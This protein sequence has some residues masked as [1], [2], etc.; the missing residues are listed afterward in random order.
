MCPTAPKGSPGLRICLPHIS[1]TGAATTV[2]ASAYGAAGPLPAATRAGGHFMTLETSA[3]AG[4]STSWSPTPSTA[5]PTA[6][7]AST[8]TWS[9]WPSPDVTILIACSRRRS[10][11][12]SRTVCR[13]ARRVGTS[14]AIIA[15]SSLGPR[16]RT[17]SRP[18]GKKNLARI[19]TD[20]LAR[21][22][23][24]FS[25][26]IAVD[27]LYDGP[28]CVLSLVDNHTF[29][30]LTSRVLE[31]D[32]TQDD[33][34]AFLRDFQAHLDASGLKVL[35]VTTDGSNLYPVPLAEVFPDVPHQ[36]CRF[37]VLKE[38]TKAVLHALAKL[39]KEMKSRL[40][41]R[42]RGR[43]K[44]AQAQE[45]RRAQRQEQRINDLFEH[46][47]LF[48]RKKL[49]AAEKRTFQRITRG[50]PHWRIL[51]SI[52]DE[53]YRLFDRRCRAATALGRLAKLRARV[54]RF[55]WI[56]RALEKLYTPNLEKALTFLDDKLLPGTSN[57]VERGNRRYRKAQRNVYSVRTAEHI[58][59][60]IA[61]DMYREQRSND[62]ARATKVLHQARAGP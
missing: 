55:R 59:Q 43:P 17:G 3:P 2:A 7:A 23:E 5:A 19:P 42:P 49:T 46:R 14:G 16:S 15:S 25:G 28:F 29:T 9:T 33:I 13:I 4:R 24:R 48:V 40:P 47:Y 12:S 62:R 11:W 34:L 30:R 1:N 57:A 61:L 6:G 18:P 44:K 10:A 36:V 56:G 58:R 45:A 52:M 51:R 20:Y 8:P 41:K 22:L 38:I 31:K 53:V 27:E 50:L 39:R 32:P 54:R 37:H 60:R 21:G 26:Y 35:G